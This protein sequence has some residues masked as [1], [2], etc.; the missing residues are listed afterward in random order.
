MNRNKNIIFFNKN[1]INFK[2]D[3][4]FFFFKKKKQNN[5]TNIVA[6][7]NNKQN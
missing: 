2:F 6:S 5:L 4:L 3:F 1:G 7:Y